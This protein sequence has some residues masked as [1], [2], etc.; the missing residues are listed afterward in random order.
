MQKVKFA[1][2]GTGFWANYQLPAWAELDAYQTGE[3]E[4]VALYNRTRA[5]AEAFAQ[6][7]S[8]AN[9]YDNV[10]ELLNRHA[11]ELDFVDIIT[12][13]DTHL[14]FTA[15]AAERGLDIICQKPMGP[16]LET[17]RQMLRT[18]Q[19]ADARLYI[20]ENFRWQ[21]PMRALKAVLDSGVIGNPFKARISFCS[22]F[23]VFDNQP[24]LAELEQFILTDIG[25]HILD[26]CRFLFGEAESLYCQTTRVNPGI[27]GEDVANVLLRMQSGLTCYAEMSYAS[28]LEREAFPQTLVRVEGSAGSVVLTHDFVIKTTT[29]AGTTTVTATPPHYA[30]ADPAYA[31]V[32]SS[33]VSCNKNLWAD[34]REKNRTGPGPAETTGADNF[35]TIRLVYA[36]YESA[37][38][39]EVVYLNLDKK[40]ITQTGPP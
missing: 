15:K 20:H 27:R 28:L 40:I 19:Q 6:Q 10:D 34:L 14:L 4:L 7:F 3:L 1:V 9:V 11:N 17:A 2:I 16:S 26:V 36:A 33:I 38:R 35:E 32:H 29:V 21:T 23:P 31:L 18:C 37:R 5:K 30:W 24:F 12:D 8:I 22:A 25:S 13:V 39:N